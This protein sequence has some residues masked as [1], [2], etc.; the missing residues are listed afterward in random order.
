MV[1]KL[2]QSTGLS[3]ENVRLGLS[4]HLETATDAELEALAASVTPAARVH[5]ILSASV[6][7]APLRAIALALAASDRVT[8]R[9]SRREPHFAKALIDHLRDARVTL[10]PNLQ[11]EDVEEGEIHIYGRDDTI[12]RVRA[13]AKEHVTVRG[14]GNGMGIALVTGDLAGAASALAAD[15][16]PF[17]QRGCLSP[18]VAFVVGDARAFAEHLFAALEERAK[19]I[20]R[21]ALDAGELQDFAWWGSTVEYA[22]VLHRGASSAVGVLPEPLYPPSG[23]HVLVRPLLSVHDLPRVLDRDARFVIAVGS[24][25]PGVA[26]EVAPGHARVSALGAMQKPPLDGPVDRRARI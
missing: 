11:P 18:R 23:R 22:G 2:V 26:R 15:V 21:G 5:V 9:P 25:A 19:V 10:A 4:E 6:F 16:V 7:V 20:P 12:E 8:V 17:D 3:P 24:D 13:R 1:P 14:H